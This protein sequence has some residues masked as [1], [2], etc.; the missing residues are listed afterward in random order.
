MSILA[1]NMHNSRYYE[2]HIFSR[3]TSFLKDWYI[4]KLDEAK[5]FIIFVFVALFT[6]ICEFAV[7]VNVSLEKDVAA[8]EEAFEY[9]VELLKNLVKDQVF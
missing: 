4:L 3:F 9:G 2:I 1:H 5:V 6:V 7:K 8:I